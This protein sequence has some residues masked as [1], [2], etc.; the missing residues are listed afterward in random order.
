MEVNVK[1]HILNDS[2][3]LW[4][5]MPHD[6]EW[7]LSSYKKIIDF[8]TVEEAIVLTESIPHN[9]IRNCMLFLMRKGI[10]PM[11]EHAT[12]RCGG[13]FSYKVCNKNIPVT[14]RDLT[15]KLVGETMVLNQSI[16]RAINGI[17]ISP[18]KNFCVIKIWMANCNSQDAKTIGDVADG[19]VSQGCLFKKHNPTY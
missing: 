10:D 19:I 8:N 2:W 9:V 17:T 12:N 1:S 16:Q 5:H 15:Y 14:W 11:W 4:A 6:A 3:T 13:S 7:G 18:K